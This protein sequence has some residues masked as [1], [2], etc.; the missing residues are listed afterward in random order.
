[1]IDRTPGAMDKAE[2]GCATTILPAVS[3]YRYK[4]CAEEKVKYTIG[5]IDYIEEEITFG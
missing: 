1:M 4:G 3:H 5:Y 2:V